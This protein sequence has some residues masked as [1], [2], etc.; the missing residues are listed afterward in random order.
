M[1]DSVVCSAV[2][3]R[4]RGYHGVTLICA[5]VTG[6]PHLHRD[7]GLPLEGVLHAG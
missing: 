2:I 5:S 3:A 6:L 7:F 1:A 4:V